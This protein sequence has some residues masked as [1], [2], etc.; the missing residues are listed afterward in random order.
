[1]DLEQADDVFVVGVAAVVYTR[2]FAYHYSHRCFVLLGREVL[3][4]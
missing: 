4:D 3:F 2:T 1:M